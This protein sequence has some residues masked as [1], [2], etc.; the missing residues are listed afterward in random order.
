MFDDDVVDLVNASGLSIKQAD[1]IVR[2]RYKD[3]I[4]N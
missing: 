4:I 1:K 2:K 3:F